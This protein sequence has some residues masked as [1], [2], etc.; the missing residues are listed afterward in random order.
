MNNMV[1]F[2]GLFQAF[3]IMSVE[4]YYPKKDCKDKKPDYDKVSKLIQK[5]HD[6]L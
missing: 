4:L 5:A 6:F 2:Y 1:D 3:E